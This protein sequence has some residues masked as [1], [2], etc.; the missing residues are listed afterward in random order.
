LRFFI[1]FVLVRGIGVLTGRGSMSQ[2][3][4]ENAVLRHQVKVLRRTVRRPELKDRDRTFL[5]AASRALSRDRWGSFMVTPQTLLRWHRE[6]V[7]R[8]WTYPRRRPGRPPL[9]PETVDL[10]T[11]LG[12]ENPRWGCVRIQGELR[13]LGIRVG[14]S[15]IRRVLRRAGL[16]PA[17]RRTGPSWSEFLRAQGR[18]VLACDFFTVETVFLKTLYVLFFIELSTRRVHVA[19]TTDRPDSAWVTQQARNLSIAGRL[20]DRHLLLRDRDAKFSG[21]FDEVLR[22]EGLS[23]VRTPA[24]APRANA[25][26]ERWVGSVRRECLDHVLIFGRRHLHRVLGAYAEHYNL[27]RPHRSIDLRPPD[28]APGPERTDGERIRRRDV[29]GGLIHEY[30]RSPA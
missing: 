16:G 10:I 14:A 12:R 2:L 1:H 3:Q 11:R 29:L 20:E 24:R 8:K 28:P 21:P 17:P 5:A 15:T 26:A 23:V 4:L 22:T 13:K 30:E 6:M 9:D 25:V 27:A 19:G 18:G 7:R